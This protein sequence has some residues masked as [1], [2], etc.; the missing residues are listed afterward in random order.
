M[1]SIL[2]MKTQPGLTNAKIAMASSQ[3]PICTGGILIKEADYT[4]PLYVYDISRADIGKRHPSETPVALWVPSVSPGIENEEGG[5]G[6]TKD[7][8][9]RL[10]KQYSK[11]TGRQTPLRYTPLCLPA[12]GAIKIR[13]K[14]GNSNCR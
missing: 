9:G 6:F 13:G 3:K 5:V 2:R 7:V 8:H 1:I 4:Y 10:R 12:C 14:F 11:P